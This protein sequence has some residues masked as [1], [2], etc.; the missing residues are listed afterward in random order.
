MIVN[1]SKKIKQCDTKVKT[2]CNSWHESRLHLGTPRHMFVC[3]C[4][5]YMSNTDALS[6]VFFQND[7]IGKPEIE[8]Q[9]ICR[10]TAQSNQDILLQ[11]STRGKIVKVH[12]ISINIYKEN[13]SLPVTWGYE[14][15][16]NGKGLDH[17]LCW[18]VQFCRLRRSSSLMFVLRCW[19]SFT[20]AQATASAA[21]QQQ[22]QALPV[23]EALSMLT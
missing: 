3:R 7:I 15:W 21:Q 8:Y 18:I 14:S 9:V 20:Q 23:R 1:F 16:S 4:L 17:S 2:S 5:P 11:L 10:V 13:V 22:Q 19:R 12:L 6:H